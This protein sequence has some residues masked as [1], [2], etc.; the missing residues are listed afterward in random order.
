MINNKKVFDCIPFYQSNLLFEL[1]FKTLNKLVDKFVVCESTKTHSGEKKPLNFDLTNFQKITDKIIYII[2]DDMPN[3]FKNKKEKYPL[4]NFQINKLKDGL[5]DASDDDLI[6][7]SDEDEIPNPKTIANF[8][9]NI[10]KYGI[11]MQNLYYYKFNIY[12]ET[13]NNGN[14]WPGSRICLKKNLKKPSDFRA[15]KVKN[16]FLPF[17]KFWKEKSIDLIYNGG[18]H[19]TYLMDYKKIA[20][21]IKSSEHSEFNKSKFTDLEKIKYRVKNLIDPFDRNFILKKKK[22]DNSFPE[23]IINNTSKYK[24][25]I[26]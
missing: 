17:W 25:W 9:Y 6:I 5:I 21:K 22:I 11:F 19:F 26:L 24:E 8:K 16:K 1:R 20:E 23:E 12:N 14:K 2:V 7:I 15:L 13:E 4:Y 18:W 10:F 3:I